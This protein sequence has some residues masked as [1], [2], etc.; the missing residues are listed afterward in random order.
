MNEVRK[1][2]VSNTLERADWN[3]SVVL[4]GDLAKEITKLKAEPGGELLCYGSADLLAGLMEHKLVD[5]YRLMVFPVILGSGKHLFR[6]RIDTHHLRL[7][8]ARAFGSGVALLTYVP[9][10]ASPRAHSWCST[11]GPRSRFDPFTPPRTVPVCWRPSCS[12]TS[13][14]PPRVP[15]PWVTAP[16]VTSWTATMSWRGRRWTDGAGTS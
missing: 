9:E 7:A 2:V 13:S 15:P 10:A 12:P 16:G 8:S 5:E 14:V 6:D 3:N 1:Y 11:P 4:R